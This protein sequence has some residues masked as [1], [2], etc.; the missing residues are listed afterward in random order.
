M[1]HNI[2]THIVV[3]ISTT[4]LVLM[5]FFPN[6]KA[7]QNMLLKRIDIITLLLVIG[8]YLKDLFKPS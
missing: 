5:F 7:V 6:F 8:L 1:R 2:F 3:I 4:M